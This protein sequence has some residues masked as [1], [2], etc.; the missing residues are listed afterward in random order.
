MHCKVL[1]GGE[2]LNLQHAKIVVNL[3]PA[4]NPSVESQAVAR[5]YRRGQKHDVQYIKLI[6][7]DTV[8]HYCTRV[9]DI[10]LDA[11]EMVR[12]IV[13]QLRIWRTSLL[14]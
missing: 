11:M 8:D 3:T 10:K 5:V 13:W 6:M 1:V 4:W 9:Q 12:I 2:G 7:K 14:Y